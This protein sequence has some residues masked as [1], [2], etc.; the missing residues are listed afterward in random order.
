[1]TDMSQL[2]TY[3]WT[4]KYGLAMV[5]TL[6]TDKKHLNR[7]RKEHMKQVTPNAWNSRQWDRENK[8]HRD[9]IESNPKG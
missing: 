5:D 3:N 2:L 1:M 6:T 4:G 7:A 8:Y 9:R